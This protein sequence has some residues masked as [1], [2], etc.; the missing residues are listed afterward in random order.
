MFPSIWNMMKAMFKEETVPLRSFEVG[1]TWTKDPENLQWVR[2]LVF[3]FLPTK[4]RLLTGGPRSASDRWFLWFRLDEPQRG[5][6]QGPIRP[7]WWHLRWIPA[8]ASGSFGALVRM[9]TVQ[10]DASRRQCRTWSSPEYL[11]GSI[12]CL[13]CSLRQQSPLLLSIHAGLLQPAQ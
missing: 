8:P 7:G 10:S 2:W 5:S 4:W 3:W 1:H 12:Q 9:M 13:L 11:C 6:E